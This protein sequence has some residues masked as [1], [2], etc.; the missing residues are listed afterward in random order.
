MVWTPLAVILLVLLGGFIAYYGDLQGR[1][2]GK[3]RVSWFG[4]RPKHTAILITSVTGVLIS[5]LSVGAVLVVSPAVR[6]TV[7]QGE[8]AIEQNRSIIR[9]SKEEQTRSRSAAAASRSA[10]AASAKQAAQAEAERT[11]AVAAERTERARLAGL[12]Q[13][14]AA[15]KKE[16][17]RT[18]LELA[19]ARGR[20]ASAERARDRLTAEKK[21]LTATNVRLSSTLQERQLAVVSLN[22]QIST[23]KG[24]IEDRKAQVTAL[25]HAADVLQETNSVQLAANQKV[26]DEEAKTRDKLAK[27]KAD[28]NSVRQQL[29]DAY[30][31]LAGSTESFSKSY[32]ALRQDRIAIRAGAE[33]A[34]GTLDAHL[35]PQAI[36]SR[37]LAL[38]QQAS[39]TALQYRASIGDNGRAVL[40]VPKQLVT[41]AGMQTANESDSLAAL[42]DNLVGSDQPTVVVV[43]AFSNVLQGEQAPVEL[44]AHPVAVIFKEGQV[45]A[46]REMDARPGIN[47]VQQAIAEFLQSDVRN[48][49]IQAGTIPEVDPASGASQVGLLGPLD[50]MRVAREAAKLG[51]H[52]V[53]RAVAAQQISNADPLDTAHLRLEVTRAPG[54]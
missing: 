10:A 13:K 23:L 17:Q 9:K 21:T 7:L 31:E 5:A 49:A 1:R 43:T 20:L 46:S 22:N 53:V 26:Q 35:G 39:D 33:L 37:L 48:A 38:L 32:F 30:G 6:E 36:R 8:Q 42:V 54:R 16:V 52:V 44:S 4:L 28:L 40:I 19:S 50:L 18:L 34:R 24:Q 15:Q 27:A 11:A 14:D 3:R 29:Q 45:I 47:S 12:E 25:Q 2:W 51:G 41:L